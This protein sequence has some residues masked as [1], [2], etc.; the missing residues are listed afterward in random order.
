MLLVMPFANLLCSHKI[1]S[2]PL[3]IIADI[4]KMISCLNISFVCTGFYKL[5]A[6][7][8]KQS[9]CLSNMIF[10]IKTYNFRLHFSSLCFVYTTKTHFLFSIKFFFIFFFNLINTVI[11]E[12]RNT[13]KI[14]KK[15]V[16]LE[17]FLSAIT[18]K[19]IW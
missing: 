18:I 16:D 14:I 1:K 10:S 6:M 15:C 13:T 3:K 12:S 9:S 8:Q 4:R 17:S 5:G 19:H 11:E 7:F 2:R